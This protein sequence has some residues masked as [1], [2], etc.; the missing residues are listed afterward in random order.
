ML[1]FWDMRNDWKKK[2]L[3]SG[4]TWNLLKINLILHTN[5]YILRTKVYL[6]ELFELSFAPER[7]N[8]FCENCCNVDIKRFSVV[9]TPKRLSY[10][11]LNR[12]IPQRVFL[13]V[14]YHKWFMLELHRSVVLGSP[15]QFRTVTTTAHSERSK[16]FSQNS[17]FIAVTLTRFLYRSEKIYWFGHGD[18]FF[19]RKWY[20]PS[21]K[22]MFVSP[23]NI[24]I[25]YLAWAEC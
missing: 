17:S 25:Y 10:F 13:L 9:I 23:G 7:I 19:R 18:H 21:L 12:Y 5:M 15:V 4:R 1:S 2:N 22:N 8:G 11:S 24:F 6:Q 16:V 3:L 14:G 20:N